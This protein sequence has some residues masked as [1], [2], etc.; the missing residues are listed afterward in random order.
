MIISSTISPPVII[1]VTVILYHV[2]ARGATCTIYYRFF[3]IIIDQN[4]A[5]DKEH[6]QYLSSKKKIGTDLEEPVKGE[7][8]N[9]RFLRFL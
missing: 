1:T 9:P 4:E 8:F 3:I 5:V 2:V 6:K 7:V